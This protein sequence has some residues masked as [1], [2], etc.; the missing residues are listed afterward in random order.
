MP[1]PC[2]LDS[3]RPSQ[4]PSSHIKQHMCWLWSCAAYREP[5]P[6]LPRPTKKKENHWQAPLTCCIEGACGSCSPAC[7]PCEP[8]PCSLSLLCGTYQDSLVFKPF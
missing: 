4:H 1:V 6:F 2:A 7:T 8:M 5:L 3:F